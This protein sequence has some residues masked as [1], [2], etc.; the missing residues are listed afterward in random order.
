MITV[1]RTVFLSILTLIIYV[2][3]IYFQPEGIIIFPF[4]IYPIF[5]LVVSIIYYI[6]ERKIEK[7][8]ILLPISGLFL[9]LG[10]MYLWEILLSQ[11]KLEA[12]IDL[13]VVDLSLLLSELLL[14]IWIVLQFATNK[15]RLTSIIGI[16]LAGTYLTTIFL[17]DKKYE[18]LA[19]IVLF[20][21]SIFH[22]TS[23][24]AKSFFGFIAFLSLSEWL[25][26]YI[27]NF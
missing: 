17:G 15:A 24:S 3:G 26:Y 13:P 20:I 6:N 8:S 14:F 5:F 9:L 22:E 18:A 23:K 2:L 21:L 11:N 12:F 27:N 4:P 1:E 16:L 25:T 7:W 19:L 10:S